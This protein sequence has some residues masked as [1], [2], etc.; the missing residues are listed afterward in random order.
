MGSFAHLAKSALPD[1]LLYEIVAN[2]A[3]PFFNKVC[4]KFVLF[5]QTHLRLLNIGLY[6]R[7]IF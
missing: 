2:D 3:L 4:G 5:W 7:H 1:L 6:A